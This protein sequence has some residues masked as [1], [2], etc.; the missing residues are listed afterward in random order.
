[1]RTVRTPASPGSD[2][3]AP[4]CSSTRSIVRTSRTAGRLPSRTGSPVSRQAASAR[5]RRVLGAADAYAALEAPAAGDP[6]LVHRR[7]PHTAREPLH[8]TIARRGPSG[9]V[10][11]R[12]RPSR[13]RRLRG[14]AAGGA[15]ARSALRE[16]T[17]GRG[18]GRPCSRRGMRPLA[19]TAS[20][21]LDGARRELLVEVETLKSDAQ[22]EVA[23]H[24]PADQV[25]RRRRG[26]ARP[27]SGSS[28]SADRRARGGARRRPQASWTA[29]HA[30][31]A[32]PAPRQRARGRG[33]GRQPG[34]AHAG[35]SR[36]ASTSSPR[37]T[38]TSAP[39]WA[40]ST[41]SARRRSAGARFALLLRRRRAARA[42]ADP[43]HARP[44]HP[45]ARL[46]RGAAAVHGQRR[47]AA[48]APASCPS[49]RRTCSRS[50]RAATT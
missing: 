25:R 16:R 27:R 33:R 5:Q 45:R 14:S 38:G 15:D 42:G 28:A 3:S 20:G 48:S 18:R 4:S 37:R 12:L 21:E 17:P 43:V 1:M 19:R 6:Q 31:A 36:R 29:L 13:R 39:S 22:R 26:G 41:S 34:R 24:R 10:E 32:Q 35:A 30:R 7:D 2:V 47:G 50:S 8:H 23:R 44:A 11:C 40:S 9:L 46:H 49:S